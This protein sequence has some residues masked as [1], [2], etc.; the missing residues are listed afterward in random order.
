MDAFH[1]WQALL[2][3][4]TPALPDMAVL[5]SARY[6]SWALVLAAIAVLAGRRLPRLWRFGLAGGL[7]LWTL[8]PG[9]SSPAFWLG[10]AFQM[11]S[12][13]STAL[14]AWLLQL[15]WRNKQDDM[16]ALLKNNFIQY[17]GLV[18]VALGWLLLLD[19]FA[20]LPLSLYSIGFSPLA[21]GLC[22]LLA[23]LPW[24]FW[25]KNPVACKL[26]GL[27]G[28]VLTVHV[29]LRVPTGNVW[30]AVIDPWLWWILLWIGLRQGF[31]KLSAKW[32]ASRAIRA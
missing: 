20:L 25:V 26:S 21:L 1:F 2:S 12:L 27:L 18:A 23:V 8:I 31:N 5:R 14:A 29:V 11:P 19:T 28:L 16:T 3:E 9:P 7:M 22:A 4:Q 6:L 24:M 13:M 15:F 30:D 17:A 32:R 10:L